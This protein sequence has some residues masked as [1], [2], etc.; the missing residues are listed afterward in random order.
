MASWWISSFSPWCG[1]NSPVSQE[2]INKPWT[3]SLVSG[4][5]SCKATLIRKCL[6]PLYGCPVMSPRCKPLPSMPG[7]PDWPCRVGHWLF[8][9]FSGWKDGWMDGRTD[10][11]ILS[12]CCGSTGSLSAELAGQVARKVPKD[13]R[14]KG[15]WVCT[16]WIHDGTPRND[17]FPGLH[18]SMATGCGFWQR[19][20]SSPTISS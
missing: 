9:P 18:L 4:A 15:A 16:L 14:C 13:W 10:R 5:H 6:H 11:Q 3:S 19:Y 17:P 20:E 1:Q 8:N 12:S 7:S 2:V